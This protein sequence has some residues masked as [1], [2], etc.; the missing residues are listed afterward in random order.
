MYYIRNNSKLR[1]KI[2]IVIEE[3]NKVLELFP[4]NEFFSAVIM[5]YRQR[6][7]CPYAYLVLILGPLEHVVYDVV[8]LG[9]ESVQ[10]DLEQHHDGT[11][12]VLP[13][14]RVL[15]TGEEEQVLDKLVYVD[16]QRLAP[17]DDKL[18]DTGDGVTPDLG[19]IMTEESQ[20]LKT[21]DDLKCHQI[22]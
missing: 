15:V 9:Y 1:S 22:H 11:A 16:H 4:F 13:N 6:L 19:V 17:A 12:H 10:P 21:R 5:N 8:H 2:Q 7:R 3:I 18:V 20:K 14:L